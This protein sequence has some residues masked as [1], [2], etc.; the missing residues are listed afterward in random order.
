MKFLEIVDYVHPV[1]TLKRIAGANV[2][3]H[4][5]LKEEELRTAIKKVIPQYLH[6]LNSSRKCNCGPVG[7]EGEL[8]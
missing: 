4:R 2:V 8:W 5:N 6:S 7:L 1:S 3:D